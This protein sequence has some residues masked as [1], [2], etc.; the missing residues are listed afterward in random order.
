MLPEEMVGQTLGHYRILRSLGQGG[1]AIVFLA[2][3]IH[4]QRDV[5][6]KVFQPGRKHTKF[7]CVASHAKLAFWLNSITP[8]FYLYTNMA[9][10]GPWHFWLCRIWPVDRCAIGCVGAGL[11]QP[12]KLY[13]CSV[14]CSVHCNMPTSAI[15]FIVISSQVTCSSRPMVH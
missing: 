1:T 14:R 9:K 6:L 4:L 7:S 12:R 2:Q 8:I 3:D 15:L 13:A 5:A 11:Y 10:K